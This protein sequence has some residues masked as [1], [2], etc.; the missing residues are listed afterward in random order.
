MKEVIAISRKI[1][2]PGKRTIAYELLELTAIFGEFPTTLLPR[3]LNSE[4]YTRKV[5]SSL[6][7]KGLM[8]TYY[9]DGLRGL[10]PT[11]TA[12]RLLL[13]D[14]PERFS[15]CMAENADT[16]HIHGE[17]YRRERLHRIAEATLTMRNAGASIFRDERPAIFSPTDKGGEPLQS[18]AFYSSLEMREYGEELFKTKGARFVGVLLTP[19]DIFVAYN[20]GNH[21]IRWGYRA[22]MRTKA[23]VEDLLCHQK[24]DSQY[25][26]RHIQ[27]LLLANSMELASEILTKKTKHYFLLD[28]NYENFYFVTNDERG[29]ML[30]RFLCDTELRNELDELLSSDL[31][32]RNDW[33][34]IINDAMT[35]DGIPVLFAYTCDL[36]RIK[37]FNSGLVKHEKQGIMYCFDYQAEV[38]RKCCSEF[39]EFE[40]LGYEKVKKKFFS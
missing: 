1:S 32:S 39:V 29:E 35:E 8:K 10:R 36:Y 12:K 31:C 26:S 6:K 19:Q 16:N 21:M 25:S 38:L 28:G 7:G 11:T 37:K 20:L 34:E 24:K 33:F 3:L 4:S 9:A 23:T 40:T 15:L 13:A 22:E 2:L 5:V 18:S 27:G 14:N 17:S 30:L